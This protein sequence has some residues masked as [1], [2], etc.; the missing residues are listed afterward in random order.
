MY[1]FPELLRQI[2]DES[3]L[4][5]EQMGRALDVSTIL[6]S[7]LETGQKEA[8][9]GFVVRLAD[10]LDVQPGSMMPF[11]FVGEG[12]KP[13]KMSGIEKTLIETGEKLQLYLIKTRAK[14]L[15]K[16]VPA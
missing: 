15:K 3:G 16:Y 4:T 7:M 2:R 8:S 9:K 1:T 12:E 13:E 5:Q 11:I 6:I 10:K 14:R